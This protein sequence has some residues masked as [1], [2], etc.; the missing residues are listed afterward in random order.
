MWVRGEKIFQAKAESVMWDPS[1]KKVQSRF[2]CIPQVHVDRP[3]SCVLIPRIDSPACVLKVFRHTV[4]TI[5][6]KQLI[7]LPVHL[8]LRA[9]MY[10][11]SMYNKNKPSPQFCTKF[12]VFEIPI[13][14]K[15][16]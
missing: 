16:Y 6:Q 7:P 2:E 14:N 4:I 9:R 1:S 13:L 15:R 11:T 10:S 3:R 12:F 5:V 8:F